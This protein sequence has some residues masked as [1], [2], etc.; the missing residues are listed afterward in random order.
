M[1]G[2][3]GIGFGQGVQPLLGAAG[4][5]WAQPAADL[6]STALVALLYLRTSR[7]MMAAADSRVSKKL[8]SARFF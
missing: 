4:L 7:G 5:A 3:A 1:T 8:I 2:M 6:L